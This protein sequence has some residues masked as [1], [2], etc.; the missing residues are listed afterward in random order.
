[1]KVGPKT[2]TPLRLVGRRGVPRGWT[3]VGLPSQTP[4][5]AHVSRYELD[6]RDKL[7]LVAEVAREVFMMGLFYSEVR[8]G[9]KGLNDLFSVVRLWAG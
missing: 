1:M 4:P 7:L 5:P 9:V 8:A 3:C 6:Q 2:R